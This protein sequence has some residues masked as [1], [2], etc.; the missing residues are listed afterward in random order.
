MLF[1]AKHRLPLFGC[2]L[3]KKKWFRRRDFAELA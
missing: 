3:L 2:E 1:I